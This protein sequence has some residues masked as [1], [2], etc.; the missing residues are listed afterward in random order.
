MGKKILF[1]LLVF[2]LLSNTKVFAID[3]NVIATNETCTGNGSLTFIVTNQTSGVPVFYSVYLLPNTTSPLVTT[4]AS[5]HGGLV[6]GNYLVIASQT[7]NGIQT[8][9]SKNATITNNIIPLTFSIIGTNV[10]CTNNGVITVNASATAV[11]YQILAGPITT[12]IQTNNI[13]TGLV[14]GI[15][16]IRVVDNCG[17]GIVQAFTLLST[18]SSLQILQPNLVQILSCNSISVS[19]NISTIVSPIIYPLAVQTT[20]IPPSGSPIVLNQVITSGTSFNLVIPSLNNQSYTYNILITDACGNVFTR[21]NNSLSYTPIEISDPAID[22]SSGASCTTIDILHTLTLNANNLFLYPITVQTTIHPPTGADVVVNQTITSGTSINLNI[23]LQNSMSYMYDVL[24]TDACGNTYVLNNN[25]LAIESDFV[26]IPGIAGCS[27]S[28]VEFTLSNLVP[29]YNLNFVSTP[30]GFN[31]LN[32]NTNYPGPYNDDVIFFGGSNNSLP[33]GNYV[34]EVTDSCGNTLQET[35]IIDNSQTTLVEDVTLSSSCGLSMGS[36]SLFFNPIKAI[37]SVTL[38]AAPTN[39]S[40]P[41]PENV[42]QYI[43]SNNIFLM[44][45][46]PVGTYSF[47]ITDLCGNSYSHT[48]TIDATSGVI[49]SSNRPGCVLGE[50]SI[51][52]TVQDSQITFIEILEAPTLFSFALPYDISSN[53]ASNGSFYMNSLPAGQYKFRIIDNCGF[54]RIYTKTLDGL[55]SGNTIVNVVENCGSFNLGLAHSSNGNYITSFWLQKYNVQNNVWEHPSTGY[56]YINGTNLNTTNAVPL[57]NNTNNINLAYSG[58]FRIVKV[59]YTYSNGTTNLN[60]CISILDEFEFEGGPKIIDA[61]SFPCANNTQE[62]IVIAEGLAPLQYSITQ[63]NGLPFVINNN[64]S[65]TFSGLAPA[66]YNFKVE[67]V[68]G[69]FVNRVFDVTLLPEPEIEA[70]N[71]C[72]GQNGQLEIQHFPFVT[73]QWY[74][75]QN[76]TVILSTSN[77]LLFTPFNSANNLGTY[78]VQLST[79]NANSCVNQTI[80]YTIDSAGFNP[81]AGNDSNPSLCKENA[82]INL[83]SF[84][85]NPHDVGGVWTDSNSN[86]IVNATINTNNYSVGDHTF[87]YTVTGFCSISDSSTITLTIKD[88]PASP[89]LSAPSPICEGNDVV[90]ESNS[91]ANATYFWTGPNGFTSSDQNPLIQDFTSINDGTYFAFVTVDGCNSLTEQ[92]VL[93]SNPIPDF[94]IDGVSSMCIGQIE[95][96][97][98]NPTNFDVNLVSIEWF[99]NGILLSTQTNPTL[100]IN[101]IGDYTVSINDNGC[102]GVND[103]EIIE[104]IN[105][106]DVQ[107]EQGCSGNSYEINVTNSNSLPNAMYYWTGPNNF[108]SNTSNIIVPNLEIG[109]YNVEVTDVFGCKSNASVL[110]ENTNCFIPNGFSPDEDGFNDSFDL[111]GYNVKKISVYN[112][113][114]RLVYDKV[115]YS[116]E[117]KGQT[118]NNNKLPASTYYYVLE[119]YEGEN[120][121]GWVYVTY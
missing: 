19:H 50:T 30:I 90:L 84:L 46:L 58:L 117:W 8:N 114:G 107:L 39:Y 41:I 88:L 118:N 98:I 15:Y 4:S 97:T 81:N 14:A 63:K 89:I 6:A 95:T 85:S 28:F 54:D 34:V 121:T 68:C 11:S 78:A 65:N 93:N 48:V 20:I 99:Y 71:L 100:I 59:F 86:V 52:I 24:L 33:P 32:Y 57:S 43:G 55:N 80:E 29:P 56:D 101:Q 92:I 79:T 64:I 69:N 21:N 17:D 67:D 61:F 45:N 35:F 94:T 111:S 96:L 77:T 9:V 103:I 62:V 44:E 112:R 31:P 102:E 66:I 1:A 47:V 72:N 53:I 5:S 75:T 25:V 49:G 13:F 51:V 22:M 76:P 82:N 73:Y 18:T 7:V 12:A 27:D 109:L 110:V 70:S 23:P 119:F 74:N 83:N 60:R 2:L 113:Y 105:S 38:I 104:K 36:I 91:I 116:N 108:V 106:F 40:N 3:L 37:N 26:A 16:N 10:T 87:S 42:S 120:K 115:N